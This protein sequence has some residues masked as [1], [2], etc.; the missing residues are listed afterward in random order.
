MFWFCIFLMLCLT[1][2]VLAAQIM[3]IA[4]W[5][6]GDLWSA[7]VRWRADARASRRIA[8]SAQLAYGVARF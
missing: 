1:I 7:V 5:A 3:L 6:A 8:R 4:F 2:L